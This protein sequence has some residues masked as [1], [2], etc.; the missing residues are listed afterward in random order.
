MVKVIAESVRRG[1]EVLAA[2]IT[3][4]ALLSRLERLPDEGGEP[5]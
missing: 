5:S 2:Y 1:T 3:L 4:A